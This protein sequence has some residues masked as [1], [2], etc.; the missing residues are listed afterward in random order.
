MHW[1]DWLWSWN[2]NTWATCCKELTPWKISWCWEI[3][4]AEGEGDDRGWDG[5]M[6][7]PTQWWVWAS[8]K[9]WWWTGKPGVLQSMGSQRVGRHSDWTENWT[10]GY[11]ACHQLSVKP[12]GCQKVLARSL[13]HSSTL[14]WKIPW[15]E[16]PGRLQFMGSQRVRHIRATEHALSHACTQ[17]KGKTHLMSPVPYI[18][19]KVRLQTNKYRTLLPR[20]TLER[21]A[22]KRDCHWYAYNGICKTAH[23]SCLMESQQN[24]PGPCYCVGLSAAASPESPL[25]I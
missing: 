5:W 21:G 18:R 7:S 23:C 25:E 9:S 3:L 16:D 17:E 2:S 10:D 24:H 8:S 11:L 12:H 15:T 13:T 19:C 20:H 1:K 14:A 6:T 4:K 22:Q